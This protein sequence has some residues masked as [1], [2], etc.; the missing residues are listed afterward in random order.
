[1]N[2]FFEL[3]KEGFSL[4]LNLTSIALDAVKG[5]VLGY[6][7]QVIKWSTRLAIFAVVPGLGVVYGLLNEKPWPVFNGFYAIWLAILAVAELV[8]LLPAFVVWRQAKPRLRGI[9][10]DLD[11]WASF[12]KVAMFNGVSAAISLILFP[13]WNDPQTILVFLL[14]IIAWLLLPKCGL[15]SFSRRVYPTLSAIQ[16][17]V[18]VLLLFLQKSFPQRLEELKDRARNQ[19][20]EALGIQRR[21][22][23]SDWKTLEWFTNQGKSRVWY[24]GSESNGYRLWT[25]NGYDPNT[26]QKLLPVESESVRNRIIKYLDEKE[27]R[28]NDVLVQQAEEQRVRMEMESRLRLTEKTQRVDVAIKSPQ[29]EKT[30]LGNNPV[31]QLKTETANALGTRLE[32]AAIPVKP[33]SEWSE[34]TAQI[35]SL[36]AMDVLRRDETALLA[37]FSLDC[38]SVN[39]SRR[40]FSSGGRNSDVVVVNAHFNLVENHKGVNKSAWSRS[41]DAAATI[42]SSE[43]QGISSPDTV[44]RITRRVMDKIV[45]DKETVARMLGLVK[46]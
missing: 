41:Y 39:Q 22:V 14:V 42:D 4:A 44:E 13:V 18:L 1:M 36:V 33:K 8:L 46:P 20:D 9:A 43:F 12:A 17:I 19:I 28:A 10:N 11:D 32:A 6:F 34:Y 35:R 16:L 24:S 23:T 27:K 40:V 5:V 29:P 45:G 38:V 21:E 7:K 26:N 25:A 2:E 3:V 15:G 30:T 31:S 37:A